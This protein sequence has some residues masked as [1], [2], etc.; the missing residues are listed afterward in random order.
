[1]PAE[2]FPAKIDADAMAVVVGI[3]GGPATGKTSVMEMLGELGAET[4][5]ADGVAREVLAPGTPGAEQ[6]ALR[7]GSPVVAPDGSVN[8]RAL[9]EIIFRDPEAR[10]V[11]NAITH[12]Q[13]IAI[14]EERI[15]QFRAAAGPEGTGAEGRRVLA[16]EIP[17]LV[18]CNLARLVDKVIVVA[19]EQETQMRRLTTR[20]LSLD[21]ARQRLAAQMSVAEKVSLADW[22]LWTDGSLEGT[23]REVRRIWEQVRQPRRGT[24]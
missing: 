1:L 19:A 2:P 24:D 13:I 14:L 9:A 20:G 23:R 16:V 8:R 4:L 22:V 6:V 3:T 11:L 17:L 18:E 21:Q 10:Q 5:S 15:Q 7:F 12:P